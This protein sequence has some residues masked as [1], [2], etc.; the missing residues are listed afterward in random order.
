M[1]GNPLKKEDFKPHSRYTITLRSDGDK[2]RPANIY[3][4]RLHD[5][6]M[7]ARMLDQGGILRKIAYDDV[8]KI[9]KTQEV[10][11]EERFFVP[12]ALLSE[13]AWK[14]RT[15]MQHYGSSPR[16]GK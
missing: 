10:P 11:P 3:V 8:L 9:V 12:E 13:K 2:P 6:F 5:D 14:D 4:F 1:E 15:I 16:L 7:I